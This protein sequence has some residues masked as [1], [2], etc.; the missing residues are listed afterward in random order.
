MEKKQG[1]DFCNAWSIL[2]KLAYKQDRWQCPLSIFT[3][4]VSQVNIEKQGLMKGALLMGK[5]IKGFPAVVL[6]CPTVPHTAKS[7]G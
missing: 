5:G 7:H 2:R 4:T 3:G 6:P 1:T